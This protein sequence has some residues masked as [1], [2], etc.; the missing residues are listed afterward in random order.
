MDGLQTGATTQ[1][2]SHPNEKPNKF[3]ANYTSIADIT[4]SF[5]LAMFDV[6]IV[7]D[8]EI[9]ADSKLHRIY[10]NGDKAGSKN[11]AYILHA[12]G[13]PSGWFQYYKS[14]ISGKWS[15]TGKHEPLTKA[16]CEQIKADRESRQLETKLAHEVA[17]K[18]A[19]WI[20]Q[21]SKPVNNHPYLK[22]K[23]IKAHDARLYRDCLVIGIYGIND[24]LVNVQFIST[25]GTK[26]FLKG[27]QKKGCF[28]HIG[29]PAT[30]Q[31]ILICEGFATGASLHEAAGHYIVVALDAGNLEP[32][33][34]AIRKSYQTAVIIIAGDNDLS[35]VGQKAARAA[36]MAIGGEYLLP[37]EVG[38]DWN[39]YFNKG[40][41]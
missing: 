20:M 2:S 25:D 4:D 10:V 14:G 21:N 7:T 31:P 11:G 38:T 12:D 29:K 34:I 27:G 35:G 16:M 26:R 39:D 41:V 23:G 15:L 8:A 3:N 24:Q 6:G 37:P 28:A 32:V 9:I 36:A 17:V 30:D 19:E 22:R 18:K 13:K 40:G 5:R 1:A 33:S